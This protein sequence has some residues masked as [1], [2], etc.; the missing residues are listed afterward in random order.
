MATSQQLPTVDVEYFD[1][2]QITIGQCF[3]DSP[4]L[5]VTTDDPERKSISLRAVLT[6][7]QDSLY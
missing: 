2:E 7:E 3:P 5:R 1:V 6:N 4:F